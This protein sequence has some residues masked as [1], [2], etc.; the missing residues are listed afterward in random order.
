MSSFAVAVDEPTPVTN[1]VIVGDVYLPSYNTSAIFQLIAEAAANG[2]D[3]NVY[4]L[5]TGGV[6]ASRGVFNLTKAFSISGTAGNKVAEGTDVQDFFD[7]RVTRVYMDDGSIELIGAPVT[8]AEPNVSTLAGLT[9][10]AITTDEVATSV[11]VTIDGSTVVGMS[12]KQ[13][14]GKPFEWRLVVDGEYEA[15]AIHVTAIK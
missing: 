8:F 6:P 14:A 11:T 12:A 2:K 10:I 13:Q 15:S 3:A 4:Y 5:V 9:Y 7:A 1:A